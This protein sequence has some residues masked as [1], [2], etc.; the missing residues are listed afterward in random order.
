MYRRRFSKAVTL[1]ALTYALGEKIYP[2]RPSLIRNDTQ[3]AALVMQ[4]VAEVK[5]AV[6]KVDR[7]HPGYIMENYT[8]IA[9]DYE[10]VE[11]L[12]GLSTE[13]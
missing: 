6:E 2:R 10:M 11:P 12:F 5:A 7:Q 1:H 3:A 9:F 13:R 4:Y 8:D